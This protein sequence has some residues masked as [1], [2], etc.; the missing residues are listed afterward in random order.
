MLIAILVN[1]SN[2]LVNKHSSKEKAEVSLIN[3]KISMVI[4]INSVHKLPKSPPSQAVG[5]VRL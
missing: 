3:N 5:R 1:R 2:I 4:G